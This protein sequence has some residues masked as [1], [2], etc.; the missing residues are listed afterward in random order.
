MSNAAY[1]SSHITDFLTSN[2]QEILG[3]MAE[4]NEF[5]LSLEQRN[6]WIAQIPLLQECLKDQNSGYLFLE[7]TIPRMGKRCDVIFIYQDT[8]FV[9]E[10]KVGAKSFAKA[11]INQTIDYAL[12]LKNFHQES[13]NRRIVPILISTKAGEHSNEF[14]LADDQISNCQLTS[15]VN[16][17]RII[18]RSTGGN[19]PIDPMLWSQSSYRPTPTIIEAARVLYEQ[20]SVAAISRNDA[21]ATNLSLTTSRIQEIIEDAQSNS[22]KAICFITGVP[23][24]GKTLA[25]LNI[26]TSM[27]KAKEQQHST[28]LS[29]NGPLV[30]VLR[31]ALAKDISSREAVTMTEASRRTEAFIQNIHHF[32]DAYLTDISAPSDHVVIFDEAQRAWTKEKASKFMATKKGLPDFNKSE[33]QFLI[34]VMGRH[35]DWAVIIA[36]IGGGQEINDGEAGLPEWFEAIKDSKNNW[37]T[38]YSPFIN[39]QEY[40]FG[41]NL[42]KLLPDNSFAEKSLHLSVSLRSFRAEKLSAFVNALISKN[43]TIARS[44]LDEIA[45]NYPLKFTRNIDTAKDWIRDKKQRGSERYGIIASSSA[46]RLAPYSIQM[47]VKAE[48]AKWFLNDDDDIRSSNFMEIAASQFDIQGLEL[49]WAIVGWD[50]DLRVGENKWAYYNFAGTNWKKRHQE[51]DQ[52]YLKNAY[53]VLLTRARLGMIIFVPNGNSNDPTRLPEFYDPIAKYLSECG[54]QEI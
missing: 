47:K 30:E 21:S 45:V 51:Y 46:K 4:E 33:P 41:N 44:L 9:L 36:L 10:Y 6:A 27:M 48:P 43:P 7:F 15:G 17:W 14:H 38:Y 25:G 29:G 32:R 5:E 53:R 13:H 37:E 50:A 20:H 31:T 23:G 26:A 18:E 19:P 11:D 49:D 34:D 28:F 1:Y 40:T 35:N 12:D 24:A 22:K 2:V 54:I 42:E 39:Q 52:L 8:I 3:G 16:L